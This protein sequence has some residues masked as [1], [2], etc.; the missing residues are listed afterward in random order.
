MY[1]A[2]IF[3]SLF[4]KVNPPHLTFL[5][6]HD[7]RLYYVTWYPLSVFNYIPGDIYLCFYIWK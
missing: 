3:K 1:M 4:S 7:G 2:A 6:N 5:N